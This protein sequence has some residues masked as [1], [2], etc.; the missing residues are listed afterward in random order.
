MKNTF[1]ESYIDN[2]YILYKML[3]EIDNSGMILYGS[4]TA[5]GSL[6][7]SANSFIPISGGST[8][9]TTTTATAIEEEEYMIVPGVDIKRSE[10]VTLLEEGFNKMTLEEL[11]NKL[12]VLRI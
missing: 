1:E 11:K 7:I 4:S 12:M 3:E 10:I 8:A 9:T 2:H 6:T 5:N